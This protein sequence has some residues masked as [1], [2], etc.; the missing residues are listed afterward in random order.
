MASDSRLQGPNQHPDIHAAQSGFDVAEGHRPTWLLTC[1]PTRSTPQLVDSGARDDQSL[2]LKRS[3]GPVYTIDLNSVP[4]CD[5]GEEDA[6]FTHATKTD[7][8]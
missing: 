7:A 8:Q 2:P 5:S 1:V 4:P 6:V 3:T